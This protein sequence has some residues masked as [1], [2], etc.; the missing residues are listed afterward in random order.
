MDTTRSRPRG[1]RLA[2][3]LALAAPAGLAGCG[4][5]GPAY[6]PVPGDVAAVVDMTSTFGFAPETLRIRAGETIE[7]RNRS[8]ATHTVTGDPTRA[9]HPGEVALP[10]GAEPFSSGEVRLGQVWRQRF[11]VPGSYKYICLPHH[12]V[13]G[14]TGEVIVAP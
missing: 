8:I 1:R 6:Q 12:D 10:E 3:L 11:T 13:F 7:W 4:G 9:D 5:S 14:M 2:V